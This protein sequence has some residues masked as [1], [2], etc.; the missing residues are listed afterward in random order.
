ME[1]GELGE[2]GIILL[3][4]LS[5]DVKRPVVH[6]RGRD[7]QEGLASA[8]AGRLSRDVH[9][10]GLSAGA[11]SNTEPQDKGRARERHG[12]QGHQPRGSRV[13]GRGSLVPPLQ[14]TLDQLTHGRPLCGCSWGVYSPDQRQGGPARRRA[15]S[16]TKSPAVLGQ[17]HWWAS[18]RRRASLLQGWWQGLCPGSHS[19]WLG[20]QRAGCA[21][22]HQ[23]LGLLCTFMD[24]SSCFSRGS[25]GPTAPTG[26]MPASP[27]AGRP[28]TLGHAIAQ[29]GLDSK[30]E[31]AMAPL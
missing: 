14:A 6:Q 20:I 31:G 11:A 28:S 10:G 9:Q 30:G 4:F 13:G 15:G 21:P 8:Q 27:L 2:G 7:G 17:E 26:Q 22:R 5:A 18:S 19:P 16:G 25:Q 29:P 24:S 23:S 3:G 1:E 12:E